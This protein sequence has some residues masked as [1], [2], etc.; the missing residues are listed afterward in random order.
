[1]DALASL[2]DQPISR[3]INTHW[4]FD[5]ADGNEWLN[6]EGAAI[7][8]HENTRK[9]LLSAQRVEDWNFD[10]P[11]SPPAAAPS[12]VMS[13]SQTLDFNSQTLFLLHHPSAHTDGDISVT[14][15]QAN[16]IHAGDVYWN[17]IYPFIDHST[18][19]SINGTIS[20]VEEILSRA[21]DA[22]I[23]IPG[24]GQPVSNKTEARAYRDM[25]VATRDNVAG[26][27]SRGKSLEEII[28]AKPTSAFDAQWG[29]FVIG[30]DFFVRLI[31]EGV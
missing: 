9:H 21:D 30:P 24:H 6:A 7:L 4:H 20:A 14:F 1:M 29:Q 28:A 2:G 11:P 19:G 17:G 31:H 15:S 16:V 23:I 26:L 25:L 8:A 5:H 22:T 12:E 27:K 13:D 10:F 3:L 18:G